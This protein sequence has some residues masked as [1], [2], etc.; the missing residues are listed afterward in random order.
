MALKAGRVGVN[1]TEVDSSGRI[2][3]N[4]NAYTKAQTD[5]LLNTKANK[6]AVYTK[7]AVNN[8]LLDILPDLF[9]TP[10]VVSQSGNPLAITDAVAGNASACKVTIVPKQSG[11]GT[12]SPD[13]VRAI[14]G[15]TAVAITVND[16]SPIE[17]ALGTTVYGGTVEVV[18]GALSVTLKMVDMSTLEWV[19]SG[20]VFYAD[21][22]DF[23]TPTNNLVC[24]CYK[25]VT[26]T[27]PSSSMTDFSIKSFNTGAYKRLYLKDSR[28]STKEALVEG[29]SGQSLVYPLVTPTTSELTPTTITLLNGDNVVS[30]D[31]DSVEVSYGCDVAAYLRRKLQ[32]PGNREALNQRKGVDAPTED[33]PIEV[34]KDEVPVE[35]PVVK[36]TR[37]KKTTKEE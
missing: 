27:L 30:V 4:K 8:L 33:T 14:S 22:E 15:S 37:T 32:M 36:K 10:P 19:K 1:P 23:A 7:E 35:E 11:S 24:S 5:V 29:L 31:A 18:S 26:Y 16:G 25:I 12:P 20:D 13:N 3:G 2:R 6:T 17:V 9:D 28:Y 34:I 21:I